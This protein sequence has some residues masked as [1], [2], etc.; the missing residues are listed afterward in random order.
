MKL[1][2][3]C[4]MCGTHHP[5]GTVV[6]STCHAEGVNQLRLMFEC[7]QCGRLGL[8]PQCVSCPPAV[9]PT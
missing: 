1:V 9:P 5:V 6:C 8:A 7:Q 2:L 3:Q 4:S